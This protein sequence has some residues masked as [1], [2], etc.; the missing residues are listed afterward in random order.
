MLRTR[1]PQTTKAVSLP[2]PQGGINRVDGLASMPP[3]DAIFLYN[4]IPSEYG[5]KVRDGYAAWC[6]NVG[7]GGVRT[8]IP[9]TGANT[10]KLF[11]CTE[12]GIYDITSS[13]D[14]HT[15]VI[16][17]GVQDSTSGFGTWTNF[18]NDGGAYFCLYCDESNGYFV[19]E[20]A[21]DTWSQVAEGMDPGEVS[22]VDPENLAF[23][24]L[25]KERVWF[26]ERDTGN[27]WYLDSGSIFGAATK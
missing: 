11:A 22:G 9:F 19:Y 6:T 10:G 20:E 21:T 3:Q 23:V 2:A 1:S 13:G 15:A 12:D 17:F 25:F 24:T 14:S 27:A 5:T 7:T 18:V 4:M 8:I 26:V 16:S